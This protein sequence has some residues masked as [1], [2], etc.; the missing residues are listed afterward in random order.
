MHKIIKVCPDCESTVTVKD[1]G[2]ET[3]YAVCNKCRKDFFLDELKDRKETI[4][5]YITEDGNRIYFKQNESIINKSVL[6]LKR[7]NTIKKRARGLS[8]RDRNVLKR[9]RK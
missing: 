8:Y 9:L 1:R 2:S 3:E 6:T 4:C 7:H 5:S